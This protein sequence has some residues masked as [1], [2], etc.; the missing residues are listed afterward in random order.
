MKPFTVQSIAGDTKEAMVETDEQQDLM[1]VD[2]TIRWL[3][4]G[5]TCVNE[6]LRSGDLVSY[7]LGRRRLIRRQDIEAWLERHK[8]VPGEE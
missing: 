3:R 6:I 8:A 7:K 5:R 1:S 2:E 4:L